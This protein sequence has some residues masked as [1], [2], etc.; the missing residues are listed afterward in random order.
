MG[1]IHET[2]GKQQEAINCYKKSLKTKFNFY[3][4]NNEEVLELQYKISCVL[5]ALKKYKEAEDIMNAMTEVVFREKLNECEIDNMYRFGVYFYTAGIIF[6]KNN[7]VKLA[8]QSLKKA[9]NL[10]KDILY[11]NDP[12]MVS[13]N[14]FMKMID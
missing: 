12:C 3:G 4:E 10:W 7:K 8:K 14:N 11:N 9:E 6:I 1:I 5:M 13:L 2:F